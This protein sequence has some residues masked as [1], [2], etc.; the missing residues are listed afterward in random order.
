MCEALN[1]DRLLASGPPRRFAHC[2]TR[3][4]FCLAAV[5]PPQGADPSTALNRPVFREPLRDSMPLF[6][7]YAFTRKNLM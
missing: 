2:T 5:R 4:V 7:F 3:T 1:A 6:P